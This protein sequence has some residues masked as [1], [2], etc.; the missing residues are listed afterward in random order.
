M[1]FDQL[2]TVIGRVWLNRVQR[3]F[4][5]RHHLIL[6]PVR[7]HD[8]NRIGLLVLRQRQIHHRLGRLL[9]LVVFAVLDHADH[10]PQVVQENK[11]L[12]N[13]GRVA[14]HLPRESFVHDRD[15]RRL[16]GV[17]P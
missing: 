11:A 13:R 2:C 12:S 9:Y 15:A 14:P 16:V 7:P 8:E 10:F 4:D 17:M 5:R 1:A 3:A 6:R